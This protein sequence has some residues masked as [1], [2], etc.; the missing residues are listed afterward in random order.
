[1]PEVTITKCTQRVEPPPPAK[2][3]DKELMIALR[4][5]PN[6]SIGSRLV[7]VSEALAR[8]MEKRK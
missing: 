5:G 3:T 2:L 6:E 7:L 4:A 1:M 8:I